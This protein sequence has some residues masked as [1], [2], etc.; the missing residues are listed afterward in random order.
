MEARLQEAGA[1]FGKTHDLIALL[2]LCLPIEPLWEGF[3]TDFK[4]LNRYAVDF[5][6]PGESATREEAA[7]AVSIMRDLRE[8]MQ[9]RLGYIK[10]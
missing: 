8:A 2:E 4:I 1:P 6:Y 7:K 5:R 3:R 10:L 9:N